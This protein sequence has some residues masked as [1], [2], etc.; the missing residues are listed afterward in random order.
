MAT[1]ASTGTAFSDRGWAVFDIDP[2]VLDWVSHALPAAQAAVRDPN[3]AQWMHCEG[4]WFVGVDALANDSV[5]RVN[6]SGPL[7]GVAVDFLIDR[8][9][10][11]PPL[12][13]AQVS[14]VYP[15]YPRPRSGESDAAFRYRLRRDAAHVD[16][17]LAT[18]ADRRRRV[19]EPHAFVLG[20]PLNDA[21][22]DAAPLVVWEGSHTV[23]RTAFARAMAAHD[24]AIWGQVDVTEAYTGARRHVFETCPRVALPA[25]PGQAILLHRHLLHG[26]AS[27]ASGA[28]AGPDGRMIAYFRPQ[29]SG[30]VQSWVTGG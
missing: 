2:A 25:R 6:G 17:V 10:A 14:I 7:S 8:M 30:G 13:R 28:T 22:D 4:T 19:I 5:G 23:M 20:L 1:V 16:G 12:H 24:P 26:V 21:S 15:G 29:L 3:L 9:G 27:W 11:L 18:G